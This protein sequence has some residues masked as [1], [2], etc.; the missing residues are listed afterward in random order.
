[1]K[2]PTKEAMAK[3]IHSFLEPAETELP[4][5]D[6]STAQN[7]AVCPWMAKEIEEG[8]SRIV[9]QAAAVGDAVHA[10]LSAVTQTWIDSNG[11][12]SP[13]DLRND[14]EFELRS[15]RPDI[16]PAVLSACMPSVWAWAKFLE[17]VHPGI[18]MRFDGGEGPRSGQ[19]AYEMPDLGVTLTSE[20]DLL[21][22]TPSEELV[23]EIDYKSGHKQHGVDDVADA[24]QFAVHG[25]LILKT[26]PPVNA[27]RI[28]VWDTRP[29]RLTFGVMFTRNRLAD[30]E[31]RIRKAIETR[32]RHYDNPPAWPTS[33]KCG[34]CPVASR[35]PVA[36]V[37]HPF[38]TEP[39]ELLKQ[40]IATRA[41]GD[42]IEQRLAA[43]VDATG[44]DIRVGGCAFGRSKPKAER[45]SPATLYDVKE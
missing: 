43:V 4:L 29:N 1:M 25:L 44:Q 6:R 21:Y 40:L 31:F 13:V 7:W 18:I 23:E 30:Y 11:A 32:R 17:G 24:F 16:Q 45:K 12:Q 38:A 37:E 9:G 2:G 15:S 33:E 26:Y 28:R 20:V 3:T 19:L 35:C 8:R 27:V 36:S 42:A 22:S 5:V 10:A 34:Q 39:V 41:K 14:L